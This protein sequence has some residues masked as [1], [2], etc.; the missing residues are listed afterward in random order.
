MQNA[1]LI[2]LLAALSF[3]SCQQAT[4]MPA[5]NLLSSHLDAVNEAIDSV[6]AVKSTDGQR[7]TKR[8]EQER[9]GVWHLMDSAA[10]DND[11]AIAFA[12]LH[13]P[14]APSPRVAENYIFS[15][16]ET[17]EGTLSEIA[18]IPGERSHAG[19]TG[20]RY[21]ALAGRLSSLEVDRR[22]R[23]FL[24]SEESNWRIELDTLSQP[25][26]LVYSAT[27]KWPFRSSQRWR[28]SVRRD[29]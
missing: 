11:A 20:I 23:A 29:N 19:I 12:N 28:T 10:I 7:F 27:I 6:R 25:S 8:I 2:V 22:R 18:L 5:E 17:D 1:N 4:D 3:A 14:I 24:F 21:A 16:V 9:D 26:N 13:S 15:L